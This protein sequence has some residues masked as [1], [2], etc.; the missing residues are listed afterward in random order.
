MKKVFDY[1]SPELDII[2]LDS[3]DIIATSGGTGTLDPDG[4]VGSGTLDP[5]EDVWD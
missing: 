1:V 2:L 4:D 5:S 3:K